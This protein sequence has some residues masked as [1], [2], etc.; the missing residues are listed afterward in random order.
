[1]TA[2]V[3]SLVTGPFEFQGLL[4]AFAVLL[5]VAGRELRL[6]RL[7]SALNRAIHEVRRPLQAM[8]LDAP[9]PPV[10][11]MI[12]AVS[13]LDRALNGGS[14]PEMAC[15]DVACRLMIDSCVR[16]WRSRARLAGAELELGWTG[17]DVLVRGDG[18][19]LCAAFENL[20][21]NA[22][23]HGGPKIR[24][25]AVVLGRWVRIE[26]T[27]SGRASRPAG[28]GDSPA[29]VIARQRGPVGEAHGGEGHGHGLGI[30][31]RA[32]EDHGGKLEL[33][34]RDDGSTAA[35]AL[36]CIRERWRDGGRVRVNW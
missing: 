29:E 3:A 28:R 13:Q 36:P 26:I 25:E 1:M 10:R 27:D 20:I 31:R 32:V 33:E 2:S 4:V 24:V 7:R 17:A 11:Q 14:A 5:A 23:E 21:L 9:D 16:R 30:A 35:V 8:A 15:E 18:T 12:R 22:I 6:V 34:F 19:A